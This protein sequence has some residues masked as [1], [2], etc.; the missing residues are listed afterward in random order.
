MDA[1]DELLDLELIQTMIG[2]N[3]CHPKEGTLHQIAG[4]N[5]GNAVLLSCERIIVMFMALRLLRSILMFL[6]LVPWLGT[7]VDVVAGWRCAIAVVVW[8]RTHVVADAAGLTA[9]WTSLLLL[10][11]RLTIY[12][13]F[14]WLMFNTIAVVGCCCAA[15]WQSTGVDYWLTSLPLLLGASQSA[16]VAYCFTSLPLLLAASQS[17]LVAFCFTPLP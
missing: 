10:C 5:H 8:Q 6:R 14:G 3:P 16:L 1:V 13:R 2:S 11:C 15:A 4:V 9:D 17:A 7:I 12:Y